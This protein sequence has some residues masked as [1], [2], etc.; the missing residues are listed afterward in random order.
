VREGSHVVVWDV[1]REKIRQ[2]EE[3]VDREK[4]AVASKEG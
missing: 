1:E 2:A 4:R 3:N